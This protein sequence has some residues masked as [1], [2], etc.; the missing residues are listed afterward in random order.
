ML[1]PNCDEPMY[2]KVVEALYTEDQLNLSKENDKEKLG[3][4]VDV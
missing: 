4:G 2:V 1:A 3:E